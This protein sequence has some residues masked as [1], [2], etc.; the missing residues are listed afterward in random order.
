[1]VEACFVFVELGSHA[2]LAAFIVLVRLSLRIELLLTAKLE[3]KKKRGLES[4]LMTWLQRCVMF[5]SSHT[6]LSTLHVL[7]KS[8]LGNMYLGIFFPVFLTRN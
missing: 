2:A 1:M 3:V 7:E 5:Y 6:F 4:F 8:L